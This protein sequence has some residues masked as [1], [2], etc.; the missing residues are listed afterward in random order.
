MMKLTKHIGKIREMYG[1]FMLKKMFSVLLTHT[2]DIINVWKKITRFSMKNCLFIPGL[3]WKYFNSLRTEEDQPIYNYNDKYMTWFVRQSKKGGRVC[4]FSQNYESRYCDDIL[5]IISEELNVKGNVYDI[6]KVYLE[7]KNKHFKI[8]KRKYENQFN[9]NRDEDVK[10]KE[11]YIIEK[12]SQLPIQLIIQMKLDELPWDYDANS[13]YSSA[14]RVEKSI[15]PRIKTGYTFTKDMKDELVEKFNTG[16]FTQGNAI[17]KNKYYNPEKLIVQHLPV[18]RR[19]KK[20]EIIRMRNGYIIDTLTS[21][22]IQEIV[23]IG[24]K[25]IETY[26]GAMYRE[27]FKESP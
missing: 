17:L 10:E 8:F 20:I 25:V 4:A 2:L 13:L 21:V 22:D 6:I 27:N 24:G 1:Y 3:G 26:E 7:Y 5:K 18:K 14:M 23:K 11:K 12:L 15:Y 16:N 9:K 19:E